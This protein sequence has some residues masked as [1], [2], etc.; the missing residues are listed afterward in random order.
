[1]STTGSVF[2]SRLKNGKTCG[3]NKS[4]HD[5]QSAKYKSDLLPYTVVQTVLVNFSSLVHINFPKT[6]LVFIFQR[7]VNGLHELKVKYIKHC[8]LT[9]QF[10][11]ES[12]P[13]A[14]HNTVECNSTLDR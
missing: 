4:P 6:I 9:C 11:I 1:V 7:A 14:T 10:D 13:R 12:G 3:I 5:G 2:V 8:I